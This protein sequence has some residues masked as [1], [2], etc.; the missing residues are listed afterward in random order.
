MT[1]EFVSFPSYK[2]VDLSIVVWKRL[3]GRVTL[4]LFHGTGCGSP[5]PRESNWPPAHPPPVRWSL[6]PAGSTV[7]K[8]GDV[9]GENPRGTTDFSIGRYMLVDEY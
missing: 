7:F 2:M 5:Q 4:I 6:V 8:S 9:K 1:I 3:P